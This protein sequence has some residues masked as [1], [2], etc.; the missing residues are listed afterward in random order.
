MAPQLF[1]LVRWFLRL[2]PQLLRMAPRLLRMAPQL[3][4]VVP[5]LLRVVPPIAQGSAGNTHQ[6]TDRTEAKTLFDRGQR[7]V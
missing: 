6:D 2:A 3:F 1:R 7:L 5:W 4:R